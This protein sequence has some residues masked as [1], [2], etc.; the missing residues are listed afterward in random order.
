MSLEEYLWRSNPFARLLDGRPELVYP[1]G[2]VFA[3]PHDW[4]EKA[5]RAAEE[6]AKKNPAG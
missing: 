6:R 5:E 3:W 2:P 4:L 1:D